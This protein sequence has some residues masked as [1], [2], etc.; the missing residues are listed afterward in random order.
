MREK[1]RGG[2]GSDRVVVEACAVVVVHPRGLVEDEACLG[3]GLLRRGPQHVGYGAS[4]RLLETS[5]HMLS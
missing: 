1:E 4:V 3:H 5:E 2:G